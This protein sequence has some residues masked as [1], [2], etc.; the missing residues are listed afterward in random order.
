LTGVIF[1]F[2]FPAVE[3]THIL[4]SNRSRLMRPTDNLSDKVLDAIGNDQS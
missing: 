1:R 2:F 4:L 3:C